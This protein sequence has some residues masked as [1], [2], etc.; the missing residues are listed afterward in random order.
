MGVEWAVFGILNGLAVGVPDGARIE[1]YDPL[2]T[3]LARSGGRLPGRRR[4]LGTS[5]VASSNATQ[6][7]DASVVQQVK[8][9]NAK[10]CHPVTLLWDL[11]WI[12]FSVALPCNFPSI[13]SLSPL[14]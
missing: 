1:V 5:S 7:T 6:K 14:R 12:F 9:S 8:Q 4:L 2:G 3:Q 13:I 11:L 10:V